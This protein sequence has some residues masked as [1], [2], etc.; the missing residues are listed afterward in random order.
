MCHINVGAAAPGSP[1]RISQD[2]RGCLKLVPK[3]SEIL[4]SQSKKATFF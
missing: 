4:L 3:K 2:S 1:F